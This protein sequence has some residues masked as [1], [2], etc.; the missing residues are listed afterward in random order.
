[1]EPYHHAWLSAHPN[2]DEDWF[3]R[4]IAEG[5]DIHHLDGNRE[6]NDPANL[7]MIEHLDHMRLHGMACNRLKQPEK[8]KYPRKAALRRGKVA[9]EMFKSGKTWDELASY[10]KYYT[11]KNAELYA[12]TNNLP[13]PIR[14]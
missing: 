13:W 14:T 6:N 4:Q 11:T 10:S 2:R 8:R 7:V 3:K 5:F 12:V 9:Y 1:M